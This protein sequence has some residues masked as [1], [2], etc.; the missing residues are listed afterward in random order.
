MCELDAD[1]REVD[2]DGTTVR[3]HVAGPEDG[4]PV[5]L[6]HGEGPDAADVSWS[7]AFPALAETYRVYAPDWPGYGVSDPAPRDVTP[8]VDYYRSVLSELLEALDLRGVTLVGTALGGGVA[9]GHTLDDPTRVSR[10]VLVGSYGL[11]SE[12]PG[13]KLGAARVKAP[14]LLEVTW[15]AMRHSRRLTRV[16]VE[17]LLDP[18]NVDDAFVD[19]AHRELQRPDAGDAARRFRRA[20]VGWDGFR[21]DYVDRLDELPVPAL[22]VHGE[23]DDVVPAEC[24][25]RA[26]DAAPVADRFT[27]TECGHRPSREHPEA[28]VSRLE[29]WLHPA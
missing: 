7:E 10:L 28:F 4:Q 15:S 9:L 24:A 8:D 23:A 18:A 22:F 27:L 5:V 11:G 14:K 3:C 13:G 19:D 16:A 20:E 12:V 6:L 2:V 17:R 1:T 29:A 25:K 26:A 21:T